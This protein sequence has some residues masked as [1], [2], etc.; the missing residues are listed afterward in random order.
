MDRKSKARM[1]Y[2]EMTVAR[3]TRPENGKHVF[4]VAHGEKTHVVSLDGQTC[5]CPDHKTRQVKCKHIWRVELETG[6][7]ETLET[8]SQSEHSTTPKKKRDWR[9]G[10]F[11]WF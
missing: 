10:D 1:E 4:Q 3:L 9:P 7:P 2:S 8:V 11:T 6:D 5:S